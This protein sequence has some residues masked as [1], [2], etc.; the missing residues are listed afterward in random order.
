MSTHTR[1]IVALPVAISTLNIEQDRSD[2][3]AVTPVYLQ[4][5]ESYKE[6]ILNR[7]LLPGRRVDSIHEIQQKHR[8]SRETAKRVLHI[9]AQDGLIVQR[10][11]KGSFVADLRPPMQIWGVLLPFYSVQYEDL[12]V[13]LAYHAG[14]CGREVR[15]FYT[16]NDWGQEVQLVGMMLKERYEAVLVVPT[17]D[18]SKT[19]DFYSR[20]SP[21]DAPVILLDHTMTCKDFTFVIQ[22]YDLGVVRAVAYLVEKG[23]GNVA[24]VKHEGWSGRNMVLELMQET[25]RMVL[26]NLAPNL[27][28]VIVDRAGQVQGEDLVRQGARGVFCC[29]DVSAIQTI[30]RLRSQGVAVPDQVGVVSYGNTDL[31]RFFT[32]AITSVDPHNEEMAAQVAELLAGGPMPTRA[33]DSQYVVQPELVVRET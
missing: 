10:P 4:L 27:E 26:R 12:L 31:A 3:R 23:R 1:R 30:G 21:R 2:L 20:L 17:L 7:R 33:A 22:S 9:L 28:P 11:G 19:W 8:V 14:R 24:F 18:E 15:H 13:R 29:D 16:A 25:Y 32:P 6:A 5:V